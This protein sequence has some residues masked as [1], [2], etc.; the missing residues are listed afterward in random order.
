MNKAIKEATLELLRVVVLAVI[1][2]AIS[3]IESGAIDWKVI[4]TVGA[5][6]GLR[7]VD[8]LLHQYGK[9]IGDQR[10]IKG[11]TRF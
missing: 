6:A 7:F 8:K 4:A 3:S 2:V 1:P 11:V 5:V 9:D 10:L